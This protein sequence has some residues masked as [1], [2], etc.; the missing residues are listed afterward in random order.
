MVLVVLASIF[1]FVALAFGPQSVIAPL[2]ALTMVSNAIVAPWMHGEKLHKRV[3]IATMIIMVGCA[4]SVGAAS[5]NNNICDIDSLFGLY[6]TGRFA[7][8]ALILF[9][10]IFGLL[11]FIKK[12]ERLKEQYGADSEE[13]MRVFRYHRISY[14]GLS[15]VFGSQS[16]LFARTVSQMFVGSARGGRIFLAYPGTYVVVASLVGCIVLQIYWLN[17]GLARFESLY[18]VPI[19]TSTWIVGTALGGGVN[20][21][22]FSTFSAVQAFLF[23]LGVFMCIAGVFFLSQGTS[24]D[25]AHIIS[26]EGLVVEGFQS[27][28]SSSD[29]VMGDEEE[30][31]NTSNNKSS[32]RS[33]NHMKKSTNNSNNLGEQ[34]SSRN[35]SESNASNNSNG[36]ATSPSVNIVRGS[37]PVP[38]IAASA[39]ATTTTTTASLSAASAIP[40]TSSSVEPIMDDDDDF[41]FSTTRHHKTPSPIPIPGIGNNNNS[42]TLSSSSNPSLQ[43]STTNNN[44]NNNKKPSSRTNNKK[45]NEL[46][47]V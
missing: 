33:N 39:A 15:G 11:Y 43:S 14:A 13:Y 20:F 18:N 41:T 5:H 40:G 34:K 46:N 42:S 21:G 32:S 29:D 47:L 23:P 25:T 26:P 27:S 8:Y 31:P 4:I 44:N 1:D 10:I 38:A 16:V 37:S 17:Q 45:D 6:M 35:A 36:N 7:L 24:D 2:G 12:A 28:P 22:E 30:K 9:A 3:L 19:F